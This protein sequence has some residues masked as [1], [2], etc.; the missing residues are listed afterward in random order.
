M[1]AHLAIYLEFEE[2]SQEEI[3]LAL[4]PAFHNFPVL[5]LPLLIQD[6]QKCLRLRLDSHVARMMQS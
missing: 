2:P 4:L 5:V 3:S 1:S 6:Y